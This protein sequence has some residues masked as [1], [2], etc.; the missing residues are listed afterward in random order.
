[1]GRPFHSSINMGNVITIS[2]NY[3]D[4]PAPGIA[5]MGA[6]R[7]LLAH[8][9]LFSRVRRSARVRSVQLRPIQ[10]NAYTLGF[11]GGDA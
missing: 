9:P 4:T 6:P 11:F 1:M 5:R 3:P 2:N 10:L 8:L 7:E